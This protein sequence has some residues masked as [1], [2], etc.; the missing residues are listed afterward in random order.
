M[1]TGDKVKF[2]QPMDESESTCV[3][4]VIELR[5]DRVLVSDDIHTDWTIVPTS[6]Y[7][8]SELVPA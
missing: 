2:A 1:Q 4:T 5:G 7:L 3:M 6:V 8:M